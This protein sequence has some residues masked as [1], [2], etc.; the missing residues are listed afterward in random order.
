[1]EPA[2][3]ELF[4]ASPTPTKTPTGSSQEALKRMQAAQEMGSISERKVVEGTTPEWI[5]RALLHPE[6]HTVENESVQTASGEY[7]GKEILFPTIRARGPGLE[8]LSVEQAMREAISRKDFITFD[9]PAQA[10]AWSTAFSSELGRRGLV[11]ER[12]H[13]RSNRSEEQ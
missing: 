7:E 10:T 13:K 8:R 5:L 6:L 1:M 11:A 9:T 4:M 12:W 3:L 2:A